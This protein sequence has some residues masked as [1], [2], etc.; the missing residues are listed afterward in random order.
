ML[1]MGG[2]LT[3]VFKDDAVPSSSHV[4]VQ[5][6]CLFNVEHFEHL[7]F[8]VLIQLAQVCQYVDVGRSLKIK[9][10]KSGATGLLTLILLVR[11]R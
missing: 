3:R 6:S 2:V 1:C 9:T 7:A 8:L 10:C 11:S 4:L 5:Y